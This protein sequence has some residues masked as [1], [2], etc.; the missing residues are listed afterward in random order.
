MFTYIQYP[1]MRYRIWPL[2]Q[3]YLANHVEE[4]KKVIDKKTHN[5]IIDYFDLG[6]IYNAEKH[7]M[8]KC[9]EHYGLL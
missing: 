5:L 9:L 4:K 8:R 2:I 7:N 6:L 1:L 3:N